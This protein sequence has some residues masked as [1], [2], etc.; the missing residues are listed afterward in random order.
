MDWVKQIAQSYQLHELRRDKDD[1]AGGE[2][3]FRRSWPM[4]SSRVRNF[5]SPN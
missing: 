1:N 4:R 2:A 3:T 5:K